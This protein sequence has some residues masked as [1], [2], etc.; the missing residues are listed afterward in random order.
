MTKLI[1]GLLGLAALL[2]AGCAGDP[3]AGMHR[4]GPPLF[5]PAPTTPG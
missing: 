2:M 4:S 5:K 3:P 1:Y